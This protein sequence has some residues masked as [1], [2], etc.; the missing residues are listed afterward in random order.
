MEVKELHKDIKISIGAIAVI[1]AMTFTLTSI[2]WRFQQ[3][4]IK[5]TV[6]S[7]RVDKRHER[8]EEAHHTMEEALEL[9]I[10]LLHEELLE[11]KEKLNELE[12]LFYGYS[13]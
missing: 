11:T 4:E 3:V 2:Y 10:D 12:I 9:E 7:E 1:V 13:P 6:L 5:Q 8:S